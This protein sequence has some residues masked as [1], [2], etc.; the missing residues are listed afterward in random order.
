MHDDPTGPATMRALVPAAAVVGAGTVLVVSSSDQL[1]FGLYSPELH[2]AVDT[3]DGCVAAL[4]AALLLVRARVSGRLGDQLLGEALVVMAAT[5]LL[6]VA[7]DLAGLAQARLVWTQLA[8]RLVGASLVLASVLVRSR[9]HRGRGH[10]YRGLAGLVGLVVVVVLAPRFPEPVD[11]PAARESAQVDVIGH[12]ALVAA[13][14]LAAAA[15]LVAALVVT[16]RA[17]RRPDPLLTWLAPGL[18]LAGFARVN[19]ALFPSIYS[20]WFYTGDLLRTASYVLMLIGAVREIRAHWARESRAAVEAE[21]QRMARELHDGV[22]QEIA[23]IQMIGLPLVRRDPSHDVT[24]ILDAAD[25]ALEETRTAIDTLRASTD[26]PIGAVLVRSAR[27]VAA[28]HGATVED[29]C[30]DLALDPAQRHEVV[31]IVGEAVSNAVRHGAA[32]HLVLR[33]ERHGTGARL[34]VQDDG[35]GFDVAAQGDS[36]GFGLRAMAQRAEKLGG[37]CDVRSVPGER[38]T[39]EVSW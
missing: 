17:W 36:E 34:L 39:V 14:G 35:R 12:P 13:Q 33:L 3:A 38:T 10:R 6:G 32:R 21:R 29:F 22:A 2:L 23:L 7:A 37:S 25:R 11:A 8:A 19:Y 27:R 15:I 20:G 24:E 16:W 4:V 28:R 18:V 26:D 30:E 1:L 31:R 5:S 9:V